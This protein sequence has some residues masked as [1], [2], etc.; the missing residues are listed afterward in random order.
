MYKHD[1]RTA[2]GP[3]LSA[4]PRGRPPFPSELPTEL[5][6]FLQLPGSS[7]RLASG[8]VLLPRVLRGRSGFLA[9]P[10]ASG[11]KGPPQRTI[12]APQAVL[13]LR[14]SQEGGGEMNTG[15]R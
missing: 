7:G 1:A 4:G 6:W 12:H 5:L 2:P 9:L 10:Q 13:M 15:P 11:R 8:R 14:G 3:L